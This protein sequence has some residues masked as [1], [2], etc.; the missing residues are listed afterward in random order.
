MRVQS[1]DLGPDDQLLDELVD[2]GEHP[3]LRVFFHIEHGDRTDGSADIFWIDLVGISLPSNFSFRHGGK[4][5]H[6]E[7]RYV[8][9]A[10]ARSIA[11]F[12]EQNAPKAAKDEIAFLRGFLTWEFEYAS[13]NEF[14]D[15]LNEFRN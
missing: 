8:P 9:N 14:N 11:G 5:V 4:C 2:C 13:L 10:I 12:I 3:W 15:C 1:W 7:G 6:V